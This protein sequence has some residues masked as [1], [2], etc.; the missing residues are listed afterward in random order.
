[1]CARVWKSCGAARAR[2]WG[3]AARW[4]VHAPPP[5]PPIPS[6]SPPGA[7]VYIYAGLTAMRARSR[8]KGFKEVTPDFHFTLEWVLPDP[9]P[10]HCFTQSPVAIEV[11]MRNPEFKGN[12]A[13]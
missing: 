7:S 5:P 13:H 3:G 1:M 10:L 6:R 8:V 12:G 9:M 2:T 4:F 11:E